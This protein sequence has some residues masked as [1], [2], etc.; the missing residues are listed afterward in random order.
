MGMNNIL[1]V[2]IVVV[3]AFSSTSLIAAEK[4]NM[5]NIVTHGDKKVE[6]YS[7]S[8]KVK[9]LYYAT[10]MAVNTDGTTRSYHPQDPW[11][12]KGLA[13]NNMGNAITNI[14]DEKGKLAN[15]GERKGAC[16][17]KIINT[18]E[19]ARDSGYNPVGYPRVETDQIIPWK[20]DNALRRMVPCTILSGPF[21]GYFVSQTS[22]HVDTS[23]PECDQNRYL[24]SREFKAVV[25]PKN[26]DWRS[27]GIRTD[28]GDIVVVRDAESGRIAYAING[29]RGPAKAIGEGT[30]ALT[31]Y[32][33]GKT[34]KNDSTYEEIKKLHRKRVQYVTFPADDIRKKKATG[35]FTQADIDQEGEKLFEA[36]GGQERLKACESLP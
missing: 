5:N 28:D 26:V 32:L 34:I 17:K 14:Y 33:S 20:Y 27:G 24:D 15:C 30:I 25:L 22:I 4:C 8:H 9:S 1:L 18:F 23:R 21:K 7:S 29:D 12:T 11:A 35:I 31:S 10:D 19:K 16:Y 2:S 13:F 36:W 6:I 3:Q